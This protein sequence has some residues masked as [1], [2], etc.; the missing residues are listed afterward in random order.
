MFLNEAHLVGR[1]GISRLMF[2]TAILLILLVGAVSGASAQ[3]GGILR[4][5]MN[6]PINLNP[7]TG[8]N[9]PEILLNRTIYDYFVELTPENTPAPNLAAD[10]TISEDGLTYTFTLVEGVTFHDGSPFTSA[11]VVY[12][13]ERLQTVGSPALSLL[14]DFEVAADGDYTVVFTL[15]SPNADFIYGVASRHALILKDG[16]ENPEIIENING[17]GPFILEEYTPGDRAVLVANENYWIEGEPQLDGVE[18]YFIDNAQTQIDALTSGQVDFIFKLDVAQVPT[19]EGAEAVTILNV[20]TNQHPVIRI[21][22]DEGS[23]GQDERVRQAFKYATNREELLETVQEG[24]GAIGNYDPLGPGYGAFFD[25]SIEGYAYD[26]EQA[27]ALI[28]E[29]TGESRISTD[30]YVVDAFNYEA[31]AVALQNQW[32]EAC[33]DVNIIMR[34][35]NIYYGD[36]EWM[37]VDLGITGWADRP[38]PQG[39]F[40]EAHISDTCCNEAHWVDEEVESLVQ[41]AGVTADLEARAAI[42]SQIA[43]IF[44]DRGATIY[45]WFASVIGA[46]NSDVQ[47]LQMHPFPGQTDFRGVSIGG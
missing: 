13:Y 22:S 11:D 44:R 40:T 14:G 42:Y 4:V 7:A 20:P 43:Q 33:I 6:E 18:F 5:A 15:A 3:D 45:P 41:E 34:P 46:V 25:S 8:S 29:A 28:E 32:A 1:S 26:P 12:T 19:L 24:Y 9:D 37:E 27:C 39:L 31:L 16:T 35:E 36:N 23:L 17:T 47:G 30:F 2:T 21:R 38:V 10:W